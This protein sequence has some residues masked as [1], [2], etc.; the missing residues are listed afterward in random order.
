MKV[1]DE[2]EATFKTKFGLYE[3]LVI[4]FSLTNAP[5]TFMRLMN[6]MLRS[7]IGKFVVI[8]FDD[9]LIFSKKI[10]KHVDHIRQVL[11]VLKKEK[12]YANLVKCTFYTYQV[13]FLGFIV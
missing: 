7:V 1:E 4:S 9:I 8:Y 13:V 10:E 11:D 6:H 5:C 2:W 3:C 12:L